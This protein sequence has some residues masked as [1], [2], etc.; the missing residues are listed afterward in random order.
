MMPLHISDAY[1]SFNQSR[2]LTRNGEQHRSESA[3]P[4]EKGI[5]EGLVAV[6]VHV[7]LLEYRS[8]G[9]HVA[10]DVTGDVLAQLTLFLHLALKVL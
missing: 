9:L 6:D 1:A 10:L 7:I 3:L 2:M 5:E 8:Q 4:V